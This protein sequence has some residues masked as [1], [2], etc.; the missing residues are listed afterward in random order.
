MIE[1]NNH[2]NQEISGAPAFVPQP[3]APGLGVLRS[4]ILALMI[5][6]GTVDL[7]LF[8]G[9]C[10]TLSNPGAAQRSSLSWQSTLPD[11]GGQTIPVN[12]TPVQNRTP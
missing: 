9:I 7:L 3:P 12:G 8:A 5:F 2:E 1:S 4:I 6:V 10:W 11:A